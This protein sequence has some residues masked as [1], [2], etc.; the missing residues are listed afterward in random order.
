MLA[1]VTCF[2]V[3]RR[4]KPS[5]TIDRDDMHGISNN[6]RSQVLLHEE[7]EEAAQRVP[8]FAGKRPVKQDDITFSSFS[9]IVSPQPEVSMLV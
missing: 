6:M 5:Q 4:R 8:A 1:I 2:I 3:Q 9:D 7:D